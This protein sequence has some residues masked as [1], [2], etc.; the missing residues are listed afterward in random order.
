LKTN[1]IS[2][3]APQAACFVVL[4]LAV[5]CSQSSQSVTDSASDSGTTTDAGADA[6]PGNPDAGVPSDDAGPPDTGGSLDGGTGDAEAGADGGDGGLPW[7]APITAPPNTWT[8]VSFHNSSCNDGT[9]VGIGINP[10]AKSSNVLI[11]FNGGGACWD[12]LT[13]YIAGAATLGPYTT[14]Q[15]NTDIAALGATFNRTDANNPFED[16]NYVFV[17]YCTGDVH[18]GDN[19]VTYTLGTSSNTFNHKGHANVM[20]YLARLGPTFPTPAKVAVIGDSAGGGGATVNY[21]SARAYWPSAK[22]YLID[23]SLPFYPP[24]ET[25][26]ATMSAELANWNIQPLLSDIC[27][28]GG[29]CLT[30]FSRIY[31][32]LRTLFPSDRMA[33]MG[34]EQDNTMSDYYETLPALFQ[35]DLDQ[36]DAQVFQPANWNAFFLNGTNHTMLWSW[37]TSTTTTSVK[38]ESWVN[39]MITDAPTWTTAGP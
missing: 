4:A 14:T 36:L 11:Y 30:D 33:Y 15:F 18:A 37:A 1:L 19:V 5:A 9:P 24:A 6:G 12:Y 34:Y 20:A 32:A 3:C 27:G 10:S 28:S 25:P 21:V 35:A 26:A 31:P 23:D 13:C 16:W 2:M 17:P 8:Y 29:A 22:M 7:G 39:D 38:L